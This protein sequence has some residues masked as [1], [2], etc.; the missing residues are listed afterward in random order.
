M[1]GKETDSS[2]QPRQVAAESVGA[3]ERLG[4]EQ[5]RP[6]MLSEFIGQSR[7]V[8][9]MKVFLEA[10]KERGEPLDHVLLSGMPGLGKTTL[11]GLIAGHMEVGF[12]AT[13]GPVLEKAKDLVGLLTQ[14]EEGDVLFID[15]VHRI[16]RVVEEYL[17]TAMEDFQID[18]IID[19]GPNARSMRIH[20]PRFTLVAATTREGNLTAPFRARFG[21]QEKL[22]PYEDEEI[23]EVLLRSARIFSLDVTRGGAEELAGRCRGT[24]RIANRYLRRVRDFVQMQGQKQIDEVAASAGLSR[25]GVDPD[26]LDALDRRILK[27]VARAGGQ[28]VGIK[29][30]AVTVGEEERTIEDVH[31]PYLIRCGFLAKTPRGRVLGPRLSGD[32]SAEDDARSQGAL[33]LDDGS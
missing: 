7:V 28:A 15:E 6:Q 12:R 10:A 3:E 16:N 22:E 25:L 31:E 9:N 14:L 17:Y 30:I 2:V 20:L 29:T 4:D 21:I 13:S 26:G 18:I 27:T 19:S 33:D 23:V 1:S 24:P 32:P 5:I 11:A 8:E